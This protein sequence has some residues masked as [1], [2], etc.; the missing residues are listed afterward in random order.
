MQTTRLK[1]LFWT[2]SANPAPTFIRYPESVDVILPAV[3]QVKSDAPSYVLPKAHVSYSTE[4]DVQEG[5]NSHPQTQNQGECLRPLHLVLQGK[6]LL[7]H[8]DKE[9]IRLLTR[10]MGQNYSVTFEQHW[11]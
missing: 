4:T 6:D 9:T 10:Q 3:W 1:G 8:G 7:T 11:M 2:L 5:D